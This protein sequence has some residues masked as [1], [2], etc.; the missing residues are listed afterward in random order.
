MRDDLIDLG[1]KELSGTELPGVPPCPEVASLARRQRGRRR[2]RQWLP[3]VSIACGALLLTV[4]LHGSLGPHALQPGERVEATTGVLALA[5]VD[6]TSL[7]LLSGR[8]TLSQVGADERLTL[9]EGAVELQVP[10]LPA[11]A[12]LSVLTEHAQVKVHGTRFTVTHGAAGTEVQVAEGLV[13]VVTPGR[14]GSSTWLH[15]G[16]RLFVEPLATY[17]LRRRQALEAAVARGQWV[18]AAAALDDYLLTT[19]PQ[20]EMRETLALA[21]LARRGAG[22]VEGALDL[23]ARA[24]EGDDATPLPLWADNAAAERA[25]LME[26]VDARKARALWLEY[27]TRFPQGTHSSL[28]QSRLGAAR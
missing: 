9:Q 11:G 24:L 10:R 8:L 14:G 17:R 20:P 13:E 22:D 26:K 16:E 19:P 4:A 12:S 2:L 7:R 18:E 25:Q 6:G 21:A 27:L 28:A 15:P 3:K 1:L 23:Y 5:L